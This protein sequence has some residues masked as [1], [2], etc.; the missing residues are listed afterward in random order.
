MYQFFVKKDGQQYG[1]YTAT[2]IVNMDLP[3]N[4]EV[5]E[6]KIGTWEPASYYPW[7]DLVM[8][9][10]GA[11]ISP[12]GSIVAGSSGSYQ[13]VGGYQVISPQPIQE[14]KPSVALNILSFLFPIV[15]WVLYFALKKT[16]KAKSCAKWAWIG[17]IAGIILQLIVNKY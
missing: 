17:F 12:N 9:E 10:T 2:Q 8:K 4:T 14:D 7:P 11:A 6:A 1:P 13:P 5:M 15:G 3:G 16:E